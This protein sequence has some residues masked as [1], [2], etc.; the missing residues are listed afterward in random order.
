MTRVSESRAAHGPPG[1]VQ[2]LDD[3][4]AL[5]RPPSAVQRVFVSRLAAADGA[6][7]CRSFGIKAVL[8][9]QETYRFEGATRVVRAGE[10]LVLWPG[11]RFELGVSETAVGLC[12][13]V[14]PKHISSAL[15]SDGSICPDAV[16]SLEDPTLGRALTS[17]WETLHGG[18]TPADLSPVLSSWLEIHGGRMRKL[19]ARRPATR[20]ALYAAAERAR[21][22]LDRRLDR[23]VSLEELSREAHMSASHLHRAFRAVYGLPPGRYHRERRLEGAAR[24]LRAGATATALAESLGYTELSAFSRA[25]RRMHGYPPSREPLESS[26]L[27]Q[28][29]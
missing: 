5:V 16:F 21:R 13:D 20:R 1:S 10:F 28:R 29:P 8:E 25:F 26:K 2:A 14:P 9:G 27:G 24:A 3:L 22:Y 18:F 7:H 12:I 19:P 15:G 11:L 4:G 17:A 23:E 6:A